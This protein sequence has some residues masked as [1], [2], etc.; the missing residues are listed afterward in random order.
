[1]IFLKGE[2][3]SL[4]GGCI[5]LLDEVTASLDAKTENVVTN[6]IMSRVNKGAT[7]I[8]IAHRL[9]SV[10]KCDEIIVM[11]EGYIIEKGTHSQLIKKRNGWYAEAWKLQS[12]NS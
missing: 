9:S 2:I 6:A 12:T 1:M 8:I 3:N 11:K 10:Q 5:L 7:A 4:Q